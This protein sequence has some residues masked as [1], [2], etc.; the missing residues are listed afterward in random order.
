[1]VESDVKNQ[2]KSQFKSLKF[3]NKLRKQLERQHCN[4]GDTQVTWEIP[5]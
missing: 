3:S 5:V 2:Q 1:M 4:G